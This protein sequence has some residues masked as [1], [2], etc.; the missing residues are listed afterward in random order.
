MMYNDAGNVSSSTA[1]P[2]NPT[3]PYPLLGHQVHQ[4]IMIPIPPPPFSGVGGGGGDDD[5]FPRRDERFPQWSNQETR[6]LIEIRAQLEWDF[7]AG[8]RTKNLWEMVSCRMREKGYRRTSDQ[9]K[10]K[11]KNLVSR[12]KGQEASDVN[13]SRQCP[14]FNELHAVFT[15]RANKMPQ[16]QLDTKTGTAKGRKR[17][18]KVS[19]DRSHQEFSEELEDEEEIG[20]DQAGKGRAIQK[21]KAGQEKRQKLGENENYLVPPLPNVNKNNS[22]LNSLQEMMRNFI[23]QQQRIDVQWRE[24]MEKR[25]VERELFEQEWRQKMEKLERERLMM[26]Q[27]WREREEERRLREESRAQ[28][29]D[30]LLTMLLNKLIRNESP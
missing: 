15:A 22:I 3:I 18:E 28:K 16:S 19:E 30:A 6:D 5:D 10:C 20:V 26:E 1:T 11:W 2:R 24:S 17:L 8:R 14:F 7:T 12:Y 27:A 13:N 4:P 25:A 23:M 9:C 21:R 29:R